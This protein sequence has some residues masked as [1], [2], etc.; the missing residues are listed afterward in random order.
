MGKAVLGKLNIYVKVEE[1]KRGDEMTQGKRTYISQED[2]ERARLFMKMVEERL[3]LLEKRLSK[4]EE[5]I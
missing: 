1:N 3:D 2:H 4:L 5:V